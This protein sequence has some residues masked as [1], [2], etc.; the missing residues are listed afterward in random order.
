MAKR[1]LFKITGNLFRANMHA[2]ST[3][4]DGKLTP[5]EIKQHYK[6]HGYSIV[7]FSD[8]NKF[9]RHTHLAD[10]EFLPI[11]AIEVDFN[12][13]PKTKSSPTYHINF[14]AT[15]EAQTEFPTICSDYNI[16]N[17]NKLI[18]DAKKMGFL[19]QYNHPRWSYQ[20]A[21]DFL[22]LENLWGFEV[23]NSGSDTEML[24]GWSDY[25]FDTVCRNFHLCGKEIPAP[26]ADDDN[27]NHTKDINSPMDDSFG[28]W[29]N[30]QAEKL[31]YQCIMDAL[32]SKN[33]YATTGPEIKEIYLENNK[34][35]IKTSPVCAVL[36]R[37]NSRATSTVRAH[38]DELE[39]TVLDL[40]ED[41][42]Y[43]RIELCD[44]HGKKAFSKVFEV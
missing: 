20:T 41:A 10:E 16:D 28:G 36:C 25:E 8:H 17:V 15:D 12:P 19:A 23:Y 40:P 6:N 43:I 30:I 27:H 22:P 11:N 14:Y 26:V 29:I 13:N 39:S 32:K 9:I 5:E 38:C 24:V 35:Y 34:I 37:T 21:A 42:K 2:H 31:D 7:A 44:T 1:Y 33:F 3:I 18:A 4:S